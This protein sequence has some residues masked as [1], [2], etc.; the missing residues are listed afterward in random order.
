MKSR[1]GAADVV[2]GLAR[3][4]QAAAIVFIRLYQQCVS[5]Y[6]GPR[7][8]FHPSCSHYACEAVEAHGFLRGCWLSLRRLL[9]CHPF[10][11]G[12]FDPVPA[13]S[14]RGELGQPTRHEV[15]RT[16]SVEGSVAS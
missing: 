16:R 1:W 11:P 8:R 6:L 12:G 9:R 3:T 4:P 14:V 13:A 7:C 15:P 10:H 2:R 5:P